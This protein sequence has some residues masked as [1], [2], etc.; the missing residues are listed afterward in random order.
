MA[1]SPRP[2]ACDC[3]R[4]QLR[5]QLHLPSH[6]DHVRGVFVDLDI[7]VRT[8]AP[9]AETV[10]VAC[11]RPMGSIPARSG[12][13]RRQVVDFHVPPMP[14]AFLPRRCPPADDPMEPEKI[15][16]STPGAFNLI[17]KENE[18]RRP[19][20]HAATARLIRLVSFQLNLR[21]V[22]PAHSDESEVRRPVHD[23][24]CCW[25]RQ[26]VQPRC[27]WTSAGRAR[28]IALPDQEW[29]IER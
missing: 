4:D 16:P 13:L 19:A 11:G 12:F 9:D 21:S 26:C 6:P 22:R 20:E 28:S 3:W 23:V 24:R 5:K 7:D 27:I 15:L 29:G 8:H 17:R 14:S 18:I 2:N 25:C 1:T 10:G